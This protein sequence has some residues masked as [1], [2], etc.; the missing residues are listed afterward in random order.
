MLIFVYGTLKEGYGNHF[1]L[2]HADFVEKAITEAE[3]TMYSIRGWYPGVVKNGNT[4]IKGEIYRIDENTLN[5]LDNLEG[6]Y[7]EENDLYKREIINVNGKEVFTYFYNQSLEG[8][9]I[10]ENGT[11]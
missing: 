3:Y 9:Q 4:R 5:R 10:I 1:H 11:W 7:N 2:E 6:F 8:L